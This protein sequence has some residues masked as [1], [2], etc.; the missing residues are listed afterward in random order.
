MG[1]CNRYGCVGRAG[2]G[3]GVPLGAMGAAVATTTWLRVASSSPS[4]EGRSE[5]VGDGVNARGERCRHR[6]APGI[7]VPRRSRTR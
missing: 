6:I 4:R 5:G 2:R 7:L 3:H 1:L